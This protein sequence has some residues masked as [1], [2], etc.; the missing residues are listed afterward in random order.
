MRHLKIFIVIFFALLSG[1]LW[2]A[3]GKHNCERCRDN[4]GPSLHGSTGNWLNS[5]VPHKDWECISVEDLSSPSKKC[6]MCRE[7]TI[8]YVHYMQHENYSN[9][10]GV[11]CICAGHMEGDP[12]TAKFRNGQLISR[13]GKRDRCLKRTWD[14]MEKGGYQVNVPSSLYDDNEHDIQITPTRKKGRFAVTIDG[15]RQEGFYRTNN[16][17][18]R[19][20]FDKLYPKKIVVAD[21]D[22]ESNAT[23]SSEA[24]G[25]ESDE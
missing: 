14:K 8:R 7:E 20:A 18:K 11:G 19:A 22:E 25:S 9:I 24:S 5:E 4:V 3:D 17:A 16:Q 13:A 10:L 12:Q 2:A 21:S 6:D 23:I 1:I 15:E